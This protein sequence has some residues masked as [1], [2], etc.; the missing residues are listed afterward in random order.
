MAVHTITKIKAKWDHD[1]HSKQTLRNVFIVR[2]KNKDLAKGTDERRQGFWALDC[3]KTQPFAN[4]L[5][6]ERIYQEKRK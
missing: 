6:A 2:K 4:T 3:N 1:I 5:V